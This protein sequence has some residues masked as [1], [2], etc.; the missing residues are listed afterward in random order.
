MSRKNII[1]TLVSLV[2]VCAAGY[3]LYHGFFSHPSSAPALSVVS[4]SPAAQVNPANSSQAINFG[5]ILPLGTRFDFSLI[6]KYNAGG[7]LF[8][9][10]TVDPVEVGT[11][12]ENIVK[13]S[14]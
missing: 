14:K 13:K 6:K 9:Y 12:L 3:I 4:N 10:P 7:N 11:S 1:L 5:K 2:L 8:S